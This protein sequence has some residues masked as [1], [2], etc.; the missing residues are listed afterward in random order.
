MIEMIL[1]RHTAQNPP[2]TFQQPLISFTWRSDAHW[3]ESHFYCLH[4][5]CRWY[6]CVRT[7]EACWDV[8]DFCCFWG[9]DGSVTVH[10]GGCEIGQGYG[11]QSAV[12]GVGVFFRKRQQTLH[13]RY[14][15]SLS[16]EL[17]L[18]VREF[19]F[20]F[21]PIFGTSS[22]MFLSHQSCDS[23]TELLDPSDHPK[24]FVLGG[25][26][27]QPS[28]GIHTKVAQ[29]VALSLGCPLDVIRVADTNSEALAMWSG[30]GWRIRAEHHDAT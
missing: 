25:S 15:W 8:A 4:L 30:V 20:D 26:H 22:N 18:G 9:S 21:W 5:F 6:P 11:A 16:L 24:H 23:T 19:H 13:R 7:V 28:A 14:K 27:A 10:H 2:V 3:F 1:Y 29:V 12:W 17:Q